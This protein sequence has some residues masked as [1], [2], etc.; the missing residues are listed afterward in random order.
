MRGMTP[1]SRA[2]TT[3]GTKDMRCSFHGP[4]TWELSRCPLRTNDEA[5]I[6]MSL[7]GEASKDKSA[8]ETYLQSQYSRH[9]IGLKENANAGSECRRTQ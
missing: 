6:G 3:Q 5:T 8:G 2:C 1:R 9:V 4:G 7:G